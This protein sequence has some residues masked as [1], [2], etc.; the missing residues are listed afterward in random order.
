MPSPWSWSRRGFEGYGPSE[1]AANFCDEILFAIDVS[2]T[3]YSDAEERTFL[4]RAPTS[5]DKAV[6]TSGQ[7]AAQ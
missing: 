7:A 1:L 4:N 6:S 2:F 3:A 5:A